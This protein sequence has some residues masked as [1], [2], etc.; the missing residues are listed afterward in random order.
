[1]TPPPPRD[2][3]VLSLNGQI[4]DEYKGLGVVTEFRYGTNIGKVFR[5]KT[6]LKHLWNFGEG[7][8]MLNSKD[9]L[10]FVDNHDNQRDHYGILTIYDSRLYTMANACTSLRI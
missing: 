5:R 4:L 6:D 7:W 2:Q 9:A 10:V 1:M 3:E 8:A